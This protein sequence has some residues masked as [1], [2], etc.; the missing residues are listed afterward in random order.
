[1]SSIID[2]RYAIRLLFKSPKFTALTLMVLIGGLSISLYTFSF[3]YSAFY[4]ELPLPEGNTALTILGKI[5]GQYTM[6]SQ[7]TA[8][9]YEQIRHDQ[10]YFSEFGVYNSRDV[11]L[12]F[13]ETGKNIPAT[14]VDGGFFQFSRIAPLMGRAIQD[15]D[16]DAGAEPVAVISHQVW[17]NEFAAD[18]NILN[19]SVRLNSILTQVVGVMPQGYRFPGVAKIWLP[20]EKAILKTPPRHPVYLSAYAR[21]NPEFSLEQVKSRFDREVDQYYQQTVT[22]Y[23]QPKGVKSAELLSYPAAQ[24]V[25]GGEYAFAFLNVVAFLILLLACINV[26]NL[27]LARAIERQK[28]TAI[29]AALGASSHRLVSQLMW[30]G[31]II[32]LLHRIRYRQ[33]MIPQTTVPNCTVKNHNRE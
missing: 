22:L 1:M 28:E 23:D 14:Y 4:K 25:G 6:A 8:N 5:N 10:D 21:I 15:A 20:L 29:R 2:I 9:E 7:L 3:L 26:G 13:E 24:I 27:L 30:E 11:R 17:Q 31:I 33:Y 16:T 18:E 19:R 12:S 32:T